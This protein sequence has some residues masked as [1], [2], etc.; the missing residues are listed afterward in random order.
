MKYTIEYHPFVL[1]KD[2]PK[3]S[4]SVRVRLQRDIENKLLSYPDKFGKPLRGSLKGYWKLRSGDYRVI[5]R[6]MKNV[7]RIFIIAHRALVYQDIEKRT[8]DN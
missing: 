1:E 8:F 3:L 4:K 7:I 6:V 2:I 5:F